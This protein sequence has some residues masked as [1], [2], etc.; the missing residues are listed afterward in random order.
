VLRCAGCAERGG[1][2]ELSAR[3]V[4]EGGEVSSDFGLNLIVSSS[5]EGIDCHLLEFEL[6]ELAPGRYRLE[7]MAEDPAT[8]LTLRTANWF[9]VRAPG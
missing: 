2:L 3:L 8:G 5:Q 4:A 6:P 7:I 9:S 1:E